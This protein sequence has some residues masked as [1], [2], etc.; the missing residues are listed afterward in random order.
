M[1]NKYSHINAPPWK[2]SYLGTRRFVSRTKETI[3]EQNLTSTSTYLT[4]SSTGSSFTFHCIF[5]TKVY[6][7]TMKF[8]RYFPFYSVNKK[9]SRNII[10]KYNQN[11]IK[12][13]LYF[14]NNIIRKISK[15][16]HLESSFTLEKYVKPSKICL[17]FAKDFR[18][19]WYT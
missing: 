7:C 10:N 5:D 11:T 18:T 13:M 3:T 12:E 19:F 15:Y 17:L 1:S 2:S 6:N 14:A 8:L 16:K 9:I 4:I